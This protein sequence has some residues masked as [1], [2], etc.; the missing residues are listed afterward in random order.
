MKAKL[1]SFLLFAALPLQAHA[2]WYTKLE[3][4][5]YSDNKEGFIISIDQ[6]ARAMVFDCAGGKLSFSLIERSPQ[7]SADEHFDPDISAP[8]RLKVGKE[9]LDFESTQFVRRNDDYMGLEARSSKDA[10]KA[11][12]MIRNAK[13]PITISA[14]LGGIPFN[15]TATSGNAKSSADDIAKACNINFAQVK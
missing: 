2:E 5:A 4:S 7:R 1:A 14:N 11:L 8:M 9:K 12:Y 13:G 6:S 15:L 10:E 3:D